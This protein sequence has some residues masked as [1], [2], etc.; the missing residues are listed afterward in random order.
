[1]L[2][3]YT[4]KVIADVES[5]SGH[6]VVVAESPKEAAEFLKTDDELRGCSF[7]VQLHTACMICKGEVIAMIP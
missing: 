2:I 1:M 7:D 5:K 4:F 3:I 6:Y